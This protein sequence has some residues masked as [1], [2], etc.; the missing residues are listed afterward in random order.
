MRRGER[1]MSDLYL[2]HTDLVLG[3]TSIA[4]CETSDDANFLCFVLGRHGIRA[5]VL[6]PGGKFD[7]RFPQVKV[8]PDDEAAARSILAGPIPS[9]L[10]E[11]YEEP[12][13]D[14]EMPDCPQCQSEAVLLEST[15][16]QNKWLCENCGNRWIE[17]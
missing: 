14:F 3:G 10:R 8:A 16:P 6:T 17:E 13:P 1:E 11:E 7:L 5:A 9:S 4:E 15:E 2:D 12:V